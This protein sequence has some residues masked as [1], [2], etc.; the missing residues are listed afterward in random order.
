[1]IFFVK[2]E[3]LNNLQRIT[4]VNVSKETE[5]TFIHDI[6]SVIDSLQSLL[7]ADTAKFDVW[8][9]FRDKVHVVNSSESFET[10]LLKL[11]EDTAIN[12]SV[13]REDVLSNAPSQGHV[14][15]KVPKFIEVS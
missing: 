4:N 14:M 8:Q 3:F 13:E 10:C 9:G 12:N 11:R 1:M 6:S 2:K 7:K 5:E 15:F